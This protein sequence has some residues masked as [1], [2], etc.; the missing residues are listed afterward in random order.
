MKNTI[1]SLVLILALASWKKLEAQTVEESSGVLKLE[2]KKKEDKTRANEFSQATQIHMTKKK[3]PEPEPAG[4]VIN[5]PAGTAGFNWITPSTQGYQT[6]ESILHIETAIEAGDFISFINL[7]VNGQFV[8]NIIPPASLKQM[9]VDEELELSLGPNQVRVEA[10]TKSGKKLESSLD[11]VYDI[12][13][14]RY[15]A[16]IIAVEDYDDPGINDLDQPIRDATRFT[17]L[18]QEEYTFSPEYTTFMK[19]PSK[20]DIIGKLH[21]MRSEVT[22]EDNLLIFYAGHGHWDEEM[23]TGYWLPRDADHSNPV[24]WLPNTDLTNYL[25][26]LKTKHTLLIA[27]ACFSGGIFKSRAAFNNMGSIEKLYKLT[28]RKAMTSGTLSEVP[29]RSVFV[30]Y[31]I[32]RLDRN[33]KKY[34]TSGQLFSS[35]EEAIRYNSENVPQYGIIQNTG[36]EG[37]DFIFIRND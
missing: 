10:I 16:L 33:S 25:N 5:E 35:M 32:K 1:V 24:D 6:A 37:G 4:T 18:I 23:E 14:A 27:D 12:S 34:L 3:E 29:D 26:V 2:M 20:A 9:L 8:K 22:S 11:V 17:E 36:D 31:L 13:N 28:S 30:E 21:Q 15:Y 19:N 7:F